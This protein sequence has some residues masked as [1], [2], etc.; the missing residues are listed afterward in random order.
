MSWFQQNAPPQQPQQGSLGSLGGGQST[1]DWR[2]VNDPRFGPGG[3]WDTSGPQPV[4]GMPPRQ[5]NPDLIGRQGPNDT[6]I[7]PWFADPNNPN[8]IL[9][10]GGGG[11]GQPINQPMQT[12]NINK[13][14]GPSPFNQPMATSQPL[15]WDGSG[16]QSSMGGSLQSLGGG[17]PQLSP[18]QL[19]QIRQKTPFG[20]GNDLANQYSLSQYNQTNPHPPIFQNGF[21]PSRDEVANFNTWAQGANQSGMV[22]LRAPDGSQTKAVPADQV[23]HW[24][25]RG[26]VR[27]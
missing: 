18:A 11:S 25:S 6:I 9:P 10:N 17:L 3:V 12:D 8:R 26:A 23:A 2:G 5:M 16:G 4:P 24:L 1:M 19:D 20:M 22:T 13:W 21:I 7:P 15:P 27:V 14:A